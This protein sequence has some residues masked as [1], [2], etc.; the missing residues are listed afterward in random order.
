MSIA[1]SMRRAVTV[2]LLA[3]QL[4]SMQFVPSVLA[5][6][7][8]PGGIPWQEA[9]ENVGDRE[10]VS[11]PV[12]ST[13]FARDSKGRPTFLNVGNPHPNPNRFTVVIWGRNRDNFPKPPERVYRNER[14]CVT[15]K[16]RTFEGVPEIF[17]D[18]PS[19]IAVR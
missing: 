13:V 8:C 3:A 18:A 15:G 2:T 11:G 4:S 14:I 9:E 5:G 17:A 12:K 16:I 7:F 10:S 1:D 19:D 6:S